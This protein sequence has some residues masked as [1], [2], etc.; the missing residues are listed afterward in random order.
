MRSSELC[1]FSNCGGLH[2]SN[3]YVS[4]NLSNRHQF[5][6]LVSSVIQ[7]PPPLSLELLQHVRYAVSST[8]LPYHR[9]Q[10]TLYRCLCEFHLSV[11]EF[12]YERTKRHMSV[13][14][15]NFIQRTTKYNRFSMHVQF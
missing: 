8:S 1:V 5:L 6:E 14:L 3:V 10:T 9:S 13:I 2:I 12:S 4:Y 7:V 11:L 15:P